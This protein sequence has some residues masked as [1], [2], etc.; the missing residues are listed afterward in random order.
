MPKAEHTDQPTYEFPGFH[1][2]NTTGVPD[3]VFDELLPVLSGSE[4]KVLLYII[5]RTFGFKKDM[6]NISLAQMLHGIT[7]RDGKVLDR[8]AGIKD[9]KTLLTAINNLEA[10]KI[11][12]TKR[13]KSAEK[14]DEPTTYSLHLIEDA[15]TGIIPPP[16]GGKP[17]Q[18]GGGNSPPRGRGGN[19]PTQ[20]TV[21]Q[22][23]VKQDISNTRKAPTL[24]KA[25]ETTKEP[26]VL[27]AP[28][29]SDSSGLEATGTTLQRRRGRPPG[30][31]TKEREVLRAYL[32]DYARELNDQATLTAST[33]RA[34][35][36]YQQS[37]LDLG[38]FIGRLQEARSI[39]QERTAAIQT[40]SGENTG[41]F[42]P[43]AKM[44]YWFAVV[45]DL[46]HLTTV[47]EDPSLRH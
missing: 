8:G 14:G 32:T 41:S 3:E 47:R 45:E 25:G 7:T 38:T 2:P 16:V 33:S 19:P 6:D 42:A 26:P 20:E 18:G 11:I 17:H 34:Y 31:G 22:E 28:S 15:V 29:R 44:A 1:K 4:L 37:Q 23:T 30:S 27:A 13:Q 39:T 36:L 40:R 46:L 5:R 24:N 43:K 21:L 9:K 12:F 35:N 10:K